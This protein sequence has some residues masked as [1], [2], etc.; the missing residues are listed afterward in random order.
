VLWGKIPTP[1]GDVSEAAVRH[2]LADYA[3]LFRLHPSTEDLMLVREVKS[4][5]ATHFV[6]EQRYEGLPV[7]GAGVAVHVDPD[8]FVRAL[9]NESDPEIRL[10]TTIPTV[11]AQAALEAAREHVGVVAL[12]PGEKELAA[13]VV[14]PLAQSDR[15]AWQLTI[16]ALDPLGTWDVF[17]DA[18]T[19]ELIEQPRDVNRY[20]EG[21]G[22]VYGFVNAVVATQ[23]NKLLDQRDSNMAVPAT[24]YQLVPLRDLEG[25][26][27]LDGLYVSTSGT[28]RG[29]RAFSRTNQFLYERADDRFEEV[30]AYYYIDYSQR[31]IQS[32]GFTT[33]NNRQQ[34]VAVNTI[35]ADN[36]FYDP[37]TKRI[38]FGS[39]GVDDAED[40]EVI[41]HEYGHALQDDQVPDFGLS[42]EAHAMG[43]GFGDYWAASLS[44]LLSQGF[45]EACIADWDAVSYSE[46]DPPC[47]RRVDGKKHYP[48]DV[49]GQAHLDG[50]IWSAALWHIRSTL[51]GA[52][53][54]AV[55][56]QSHFFLSRSATFRDGAQAILLAADLL[57]Y[58]DAEKE[59]I[60]SV[61]RLRGIL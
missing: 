6:F 3:D 5:A 51:G 8:G 52:K 25:N 15:L 39:G 43:E 26:G 12:R 28:P 21:R 57:N 41:W 36:S 24:A 4:P 19:G 29:R 34:I 44:A 27:Y 16:P 17:I 55:I 23:D 46:T 53:A 20:S 33:V 38:T 50:E 37:R 54:D 10:E 35:T 32:L 31:Y 13:L 42:R 56:L 40:A 48:E 9:T 11:A 14:Y 60:R 61:F 22:R 30:M 7:F 59:T 2:F 47:L 45:Q 49:V 58:A 18:R 1:T